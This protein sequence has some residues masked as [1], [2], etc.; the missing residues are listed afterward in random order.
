[1]VLNPAMRFVL[2]ISLCLG[3]VVSA[4]GSG[5]DLTSW[6]DTGLQLG[7]TSSPAKVITTTPPRPTPWTTR[8]GSKGGAEEVRR[9]VE[10]LLGGLGGSEFGSLTLAHR[11]AAT[12]GYCTI[13][14]QFRR[15]H[16]AGLMYACAFRTENRITCIRLR[17]R[18]LWGP[19]S[20]KAYPAWLCPCVHHTNISSMVVALYPRH[21]SAGHQPKIAQT[22]MV[23]FRYPQVHPG[24]VYRYK[25][26][27]LCTYIFL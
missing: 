15:S 23:T 5:V 11:G 3:V 12:S 9:V 13:A 22:C 14:L 17:Q 2:Y 8:G 26:S 6:A 25:F 20:T 21:T 7:A 1:M 4:T 27:G 10:V 24:R 16:F 19:T 18:L